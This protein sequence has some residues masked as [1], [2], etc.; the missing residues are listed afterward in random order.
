MGL[1]G[2]RHT[3][4]PRAL[5]AE[6]SGVESGRSDV[7]GGRLLAVSGGGAAGA[8]RRRAGDEPIAQV[9]LAAAEPVAA[10]AQLV[11]LDALLRDGH[12]VAHRGVPQAGVGQQPA[13]A[14]Q[15]RRSIEGVPPSPLEAKVRECSSVVEGCEYS[16]A[17]CL[18]RHAVCADAAARSSDASAHHVILRTLTRY[19]SRTYGV[20]YITLLAHNVALSPEIRAL[21]GTK[22]KC[23]VNK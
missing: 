5:E 14:V 16:G 1:L 15:V 4:A 8:E 23:E 22:I 18:F 6:P 9:G 13:V 20:F 21:K 3:L 10:A 7:R 2:A 19:Y 11:A 17:V 12:L